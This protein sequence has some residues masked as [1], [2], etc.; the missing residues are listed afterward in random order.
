MNHEK[1]FKVTVNF[2]R[3]AVSFDCTLDYEP[4]NFIQL[5]IISLH[6]S[7]L[8]ILDN[9]NFLCQHLV[10]ITDIVDLTAR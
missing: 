5:I 7:S 4:V 10:R 6:S 2:L 1:L 9:N 3:R 8:K